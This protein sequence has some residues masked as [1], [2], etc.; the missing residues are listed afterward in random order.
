M[1]T[2]AEERHLQRLILEDCI[3]VQLAMQEQ[4]GFPI[5]NNA[6]IR[7]RQDYLNEFLLADP[8]RIPVIRKASLVRENLLAWEYPLK[9][10]HLEL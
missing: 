6:I 7:S 1:T 3:D 10:K 8:N 4:T 2:A 5:K 9:F